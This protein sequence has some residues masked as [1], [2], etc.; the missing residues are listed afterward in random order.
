VRARPRDASFAALCNYSRQNERQEHHSRDT[1]AIA[2]SLHAIG[3]R[4]SLLIIRDALTRTQ[5]FG[6]FQKQLGIAKNIVTMRLRKL[7]TEGIME[8][9][10]ASD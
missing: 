10:T 6:A 9:T 2:R 4:W 1:S 5:R 3:D 8:P 7:V